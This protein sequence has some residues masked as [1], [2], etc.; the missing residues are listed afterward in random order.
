[1]YYAIMGF[2]S[3]ESLAKRK[4]A[5]PTHLERIK[6]LVD[7]GRILVAGPHPAI[8]SPDPGPNGFTG[9][10]IIGEFESQEAA[11]KWINDD[12]Y[13]KD[14]VFERVEVKPFLKVLP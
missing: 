11:E 8:D 3:T 9:S 14:G 1:M 5:R 4:D 10:L 13:V 12:P 7:E 2:D 6:K